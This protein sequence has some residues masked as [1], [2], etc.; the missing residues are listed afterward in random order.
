MPVP[1]SI[2]TRLRRLFHATILGVLAL[3]SV[4][5]GDNPF[6]PY[7]DGG[8]YELR[9]A[10]NYPVPAVVSGGY[11]PNAIRTEVTSG[12]LTLRRDHSYQL[13][14]D[15]IDWDHGVAYESTVAFVGRYENEGRILYLNYFSVGEAYSSVMVATWRHGRIEIVVPEVDVDL[16]AGVLCV[17]DDR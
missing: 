17:F 3:A 8:T 10:N 4:A 7:W 5:C 2:Q 6:S 1:L 13:L 16:R 11:G 15:V 12:T 14:V 9:Y